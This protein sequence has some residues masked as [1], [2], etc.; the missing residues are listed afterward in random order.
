MDDWNIPEIPQDQLYVPKTIKD[1]H[2]FDYIIKI[3][4]NN[5]PL[6]HKYKYLHIGC[7]QVAIKPLIDMDIDAAVLAKIY[8]A[9]ILEVSGK[10]SNGQVGSK[11]A[12]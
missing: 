7:V 5:I 11:N 8:L 1:K 6:R 2:N 12:V 10:G 3:V 4:E 9:P